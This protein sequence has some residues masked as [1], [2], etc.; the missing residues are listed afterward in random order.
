[1]VV[2]RN[3]IGVSVKKNTRNGAR[4]AGAAE[5]A[6]G[7]ARAAGAPLSRHDE[8][9]HLS[10]I[11][12]AHALDAHLAELYLE[13]MRDAAGSLLDDLLDRFQTLVKAGHD[14][15]VVVRKEILP[16]TALGPIAKAVLLLWYI[17]GI[18][19][20][21]GGDWE[22]QSADQYYRALVWEAIGAH[23]PTLSNGYFGHWKYPPE[24]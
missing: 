5:P 13:R 11:L 22:M 15:L 10:R 24:M 17:G 12:T 21:P 9:L 6:K 3:F 20:I 1:V 4:Q 23:P 8:F 7:K 16:D 2:G 14:P 19:K 18:Q